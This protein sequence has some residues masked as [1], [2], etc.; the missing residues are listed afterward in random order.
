MSDT[1]NEKK[2]IRSLIKQLSKEFGTIL[3]EEY[4]LRD[5]G[6]GLK[7][8]GVSREKDICI[9]VCCNKLRVGRDRV[10]AGQLDSI[11]RRCYLLSIS[12]YNNKLLVFIDRDF[13]EQI[14]EKYYDYLV[15][16]KAEYREIS[17]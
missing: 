13:Y 6:Y 8:H 5:K 10:D 7:C 15:E 12:P 2:Q 14:I 9:F 16:I 17:E 3:N 11:L 1:I 4:I